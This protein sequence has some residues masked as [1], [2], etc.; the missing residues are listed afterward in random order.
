VPRENNRNLE[1]AVARIVLL[2]AAVVEFVLRGLLTLFGSEPVAKLFGLEYVK[3][4]L[5][6]AHPFGALMLTFGVIFVLALRKPDKH[7]FVID[8]GV[9]RYVLGPC[10][11]S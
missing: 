4:A 2:I 1:G 10:R 3:R 8:M 11:S 9:L 7:K 6:Y 5:V